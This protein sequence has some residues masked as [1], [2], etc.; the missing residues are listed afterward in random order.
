MNYK[1]EVLR[2]Y[3]FKKEFIFKEFVDYF[4]KM[5]VT[6]DKNSPQFTISKL[7]LNSLYGR[8]GM[9]PYKEKHIITNRSES[10]EIYNK[11]NVTN[12]INFDYKELISYLDFNESD[13]EYINL[14][15]SIPIASAVTAYA[16]MYM[17]EFKTLNNNKCYY[18]DTD[19]VFLEKNLDDSYVGSEIGKFKLEYTSKKAIFL[20]PKVY[21]CKTNLGDICKIKGFKLNKNDVINTI[22]FED[23]YDLLYKDKTILLNHEKWNKN[24]ASGNITIDNDKYTLKTTLGKRELIF[25]KSNKFVDTKPL[26]LVNGDLE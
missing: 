1:I 25:N 22:K 21:Y 5:K 13:D 2:G 19:S 17:Y 20:A 23:F 18:T 10:T 9:S 14:N 6:N 12:V 24:L 3:V 7:I 16:R 15:I 26:Y 8:F 4:Y 11:F